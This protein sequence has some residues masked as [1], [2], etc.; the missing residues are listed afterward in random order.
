[1]EQADVNPNEEERRRRLTFPVAGG[2]FAGTELIDEL[3]DLVHSVLRNYPNIRPDE[4]RFV[5][6]HSR[7]R[8]LPELGPKL[9]DYALGKLQ[10]RGLEFYLG[11]R[12]QGATLDSVIVGDD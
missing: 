9:A 2:G 3:F 11:V 12:V 5:L 10:V 8:I 6:I 4:T 1:M 7:D